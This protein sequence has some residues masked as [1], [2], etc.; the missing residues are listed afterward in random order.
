[1]KDAFHLSDGFKTI[2][3]IGLIIFVILF[4]MSLTGTFKDVKLP[5]FIEKSNTL[6]LIFY[7]LVVIV[8]ILML[9]YLDYF[10]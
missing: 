4:L 10:K 9:I 6:T 1:M 7:A 8:S 5:K 3:N 2:I